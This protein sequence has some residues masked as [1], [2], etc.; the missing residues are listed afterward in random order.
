MKN[1]RLARDKTCTNKPYKLAHKIEEKSVHFFVVAQVVVSFRRLF[2]AFSVPLLLLCLRYCYIT[3]HICA[4]IWLEQIK[5]LYALFVDSAQQQQQ[6]WHRHRRKKQRSR[7]LSFTRILQEDM[8]RWRQR[9][10]KQ[11]KQKRKRD[12][13]A[14]TPPL[15]SIQWPKQH[16][17]QHHLSID[18]VNV[19]CVVW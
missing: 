6:H 14:T 5:H 17:N 18:E 4:D 11:N 1:V 10:W 15:N 8:Q 7:R 3:G 19:C 16:L 12:A 2:T 9:W 13:K